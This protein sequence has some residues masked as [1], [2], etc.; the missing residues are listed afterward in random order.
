MTLRGCVR[1]FIHGPFDMT[2]E[3]KWVLAYLIDEDVF[4][5]GFLVCKYVTT[6]NK[7]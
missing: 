6:S 7:Q 4:A 2:G 5:C 1:H 3:R